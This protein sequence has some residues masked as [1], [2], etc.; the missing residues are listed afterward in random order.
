[1]LVGAAA[2]V[3]ACE[4]G[5]RISK[6]TGELIQPI[7]IQ[8]SS[9]RAVRVNVLVGRRDLDSPLLL[10]P[11]LGVK[12]TIRSGETLKYDVVLAD[13][14]EKDPPFADELVFRYRVEVIYPHWRV[15]RVMWYEMLGPLPEMVR[16]NDGFSG[17]VL[18]SPGLDFA[19]VPETFWQLEEQANALIQAEKSGEIGGTEFPEEEAPEAS[20]AK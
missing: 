4:T 18:S 3:P 14:D 19:I 1:M 15:P 5:P 20:E 10:G 13:P 7:K 2:F 11:R 12:K 8:N 6:E 17:V 9:T 16:L